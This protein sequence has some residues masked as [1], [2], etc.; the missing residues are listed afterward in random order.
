MT[1]AMSPPLRLVWKSDVAF[2]VAV[3]SDATMY[4]ITPPGSLTALNSNDGSVKWVSQNTYVPTRLVRHGQRLIAYRAGEGLG[5]VDDQGLSASEV[6]VASFGASESAHMST[7]VVDDQMIYFVLE[8]GLYAIHQDQGPQFLAVLE[9]NHPHSVGYVSPSQIVVVDGKGLPTRYAVLGDR[10]EAV[11]RGTPH[12]VPTGQTERPFVV[13]G[14][15]LVVA[16]GETLI[17]Y[18]LATGHIA[19]RRSNIPLHTLSVRDGIVYGGFLGAAL[20]A[21][22]LQDGAMLWQRQYVYDLAVLRDVSITLAGEHLFLG[23]SLYG[24][25]DQALLLAVRAQDGGPVWL[26]RSATYDWAGGTPVF[27]GTRICTYN[28]HYS[29]AYVPMNGA[30]RVGPEHF[31]VSPRPLRGPSSTFGGG[32]I[33]VSLPVD[34]RIS[35]ATYREREGIGTLIVDD[36]NW[37]AGVHEVA[38]NPTGTGGFT[39]ENQFGYMLVD[40][41][42]TGGPSYTQTILIPVNTFPDITYHWARHYIE[43]MAYH[44][45]V[46]G[47]PDQTFRPNNLVTRAESSTIIAKT[48]DLHAPSPGFET[49]FTDIGTHWARNYIMALEEQGII[50]GFEEP[51]GTYTFRPEL[52][53]TRA[54]EARILVNAYEIPAAPEG[55]R[56]RF[57]DIDGHWAEKDIE[58]LE[59]AGYVNG[60]REPDG[61]YTYRP[62]Q[63]LTR[64]ELC[65]V[66][67]RI[68]NLS[69]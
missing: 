31:T 33:Q 7:P 38:W 52:N 26:S 34:A 45:F 18:D 4:G 51:D 66:V 9:E 3:A 37:S 27:D 16:V 1:R 59:A 22:Q 24:N 49:K 5:F 57:T 39:D 47:Y 53:M 48:L 32:A 14:D 56:T 46:S 64:A 8:R 35:V 25:P 20:W 30:P 65:T 43:T 60:F 13:A 50:S 12:N 2:R 17:A 21:V 44:R 6:L 41:N 63:P 69:R 15:R 62:E 67:V 29:A 58:A 10:F 23:G 19:W 42:E 28:S 68:R 54:Q 55:F 40:V 11:W 61:T 36:A